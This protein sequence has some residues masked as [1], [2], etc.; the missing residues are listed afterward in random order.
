MDE[1]FRP[2]D[3]D[4]IRILPIAGELDMSNSDKLESAI[5]DA[6]DAKRPLIIDL[7]AL[8]Y[9][10]STVLNVLIREHKKSEGR[11]Q[12]VLPSTSKLRRVFELLYFD[13]IFNVDE[14]IESAIERSKATH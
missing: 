13:R 6:I 5:G 4:G 3:R 1:L 12:V 2:Y 14:T 8:H 10:D 11:I 9:C 7:T